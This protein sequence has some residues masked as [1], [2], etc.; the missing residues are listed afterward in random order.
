MTPAP[1]EGGRDVVAA[2][3]YELFWDCLE[4]DVPAGE[5]VPSCDQAGDAY[6]QFWQQADG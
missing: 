2:D 1:V 5:D 6:H 4:N 3:A